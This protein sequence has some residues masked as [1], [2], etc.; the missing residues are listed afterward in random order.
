MFVTME[1]S[2]VTAQ[3]ATLSSRSLDTDRKLLCNAFSNIVYYFCILSFD[4]NCMQPYILLTN[5][6]SSERR[7]HI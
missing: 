6:G 1:L 3:G 7:D 4:I 2:I 5:E